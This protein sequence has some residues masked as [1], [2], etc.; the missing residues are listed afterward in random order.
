MAKNDSVSSVSAGK[1][2]ISI[3]DFSA[4]GIYSSLIYGLDRKECRDF[5]WAKSKTDGEY[6]C[7]NAFG[8]WTLSILPL[9]DGSVEVE[10]S[11]KLAQ[12]LKKLVLRPICID[13]LTTEHILV[14]GRRMGGCKNML[15]KN[16]K[17][18]T[19][20][21]SSFQHLM[22]A[23]GITV[24]FSHRLMQKDLSYIGGTAVKGGV[25][26]FYVESECEDCEKG[27]TIA[28]EKLTIK[29]SKDGYALMRGW[30]ETNIEVKKK[31]AEFKPGWNSW[32]YYRWTITEKEVLENAEFIAA[33]PV[34][35]KH[36]KRI[37]VDDGWQYC[38]GEWEANPLFPSG[39]KSLASDI[40]KLGFEPG[41]WF[42]PTIIEPHCR[43]AQLDSW[44]LATGESGLPCLAYECMR[45][46]GFV[47]DPTQKKVQD[48]IYELFKRYTDMGYQYFKLDF[49]G[50]TLKAPYFADKSVPKGEIIRRI[51]EPARRAAGKKAEILGCNYHFEAGNKYVDAVRVSSDIGPTWHAVCEN[52]YSIADRFWSNGSFWIND[53]DF[54][55]CRGQE[56]SN[57][58]DLE[59]LRHCLVFVDPKDTEPGDRNRSLVNI[60]YDE[61]VIL[62]SLVLISSGAM[63]LSDKMSRLNKKGLELAR[64]V[65]A[66]ERG[67]TGIPLDLFSSDRPAF[68]LQKLAA[69]RS[70][71]LLINWDDKAKSMSFDLA[72]NGL[73]YSK[74]SDFW[75]GSQI[76]MK[77]GK[78]EVNLAP[79]SC[80]LAELG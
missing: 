15:T 45:R 61:I 40:K 37:I 20:F 44:M 53:P 64:K 66:A 51:V 4:S 38:Y 80:L 58:P 36:I 31:P 19:D 77:A 35:S 78:T 11:G 70:R 42:A 14:H 48:W 8:T 55:L 29:T 9:K 3:P 75:T 52:V 62:L 33:D 21:R 57:D 27:K 56:T 39:M 23:K 32:D 60:T 72:K 69:G 76:K 16:I 41:L 73:N 12:S 28:S 13:S 25:K 30:G 63:N 74:A 65:V 68:W 71:L 17:K 5:K 67:E 2:S 47:L 50:S 43:I 26:N 1:I 34:L 49:L 59:R 46:F 79:H 54:T 6:T 10:M 24:Q 7:K 18:D 22:T